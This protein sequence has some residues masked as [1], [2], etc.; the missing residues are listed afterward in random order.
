M[1]YNSGEDT[2]VV[3]QNETVCHI[4][5][6]TTFT[7]YLLIFWPKRF[8]F[9]LLT[10]IDYKSAVDLYFREY[11]SNALNQ[12]SR[13]NLAQLIKQFNVQSSHFE[14]LFDKFL[15]ILLNVHDTKIIKEFIKKVM[16]NT[17]SMNQAHIPKLVTLIELLE[18]VCLIDFFKKFATKNLLNDCLL[19]ESLLESINKNISNIYFEASIVPLLDKQET[20][21]PKF[22]NDPY[23]YFRLIELLFYFPNKY[24]EKFTEK[25]LNKLDQESLKTLVEYLIVNHAAECTKEPLIE[26]VIQRINWLR[27]LLRK[28][29]V[30]SYNMK[31]EAIEDKQVEEFLKSN[32]REFTY[33]GVFNGIGQVREFISLFG[34]NGEGYSIEMHASGVGKKAQVHI[35]KTRAFFERELAKFEE[36]RREMKSI[37]KLKLKLKF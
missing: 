34:V 29:P 37:E 6:T 10:E 15:E 1:F 28:K 26:L 9:D 36:A 12:T 3:D 21:F 16:S 35:V 13:H 18:P 33:S 19:L 22:S 2:A 7:K 23:T 24:L 27:E 11:S 31:C 25:V 5:Q 4:Y 20:Q 17:S 32:R 8:E 14:Y 30:F